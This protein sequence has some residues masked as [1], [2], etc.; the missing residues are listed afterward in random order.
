[1]S[2]RLELDGRIA[3]LVIDRPDKRNAMS[4]AMW[5]AI[6]ELVERVRADD[7]VRVLLVRGGEHFSAGADIGEF[8]ELRRGV[9]ATARYS[10]VVHAGEQ[11]LAT[12]EKPTIASVDGFCVGGGCELALACDIRI[13]SARARFGI[14]PAKL[15]IVYSLTA[16]KRLVDV[17][18]PSWAKQVLLTG[19]LVDAAVALRIGLVNEV[20]EDLGARTAELAAVIA[21]RA[22]V[23]VLG[24]KQIVER[25][26]AGE[27]EESAEVAELYDAAVR[28]AEYAEG[29]AAFL[30]KRAPVF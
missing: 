18:G 10:A 1:M 22:P 30:E 11:A 7:A 5:R 9:E 23:S 26:V 14:T 20:V 29:V 8:G 2:L 13:A 17:V 15:G 27:R 19:E 4:F 12:L 16:T 25:V 24:M 28:S 21:S 6:P 3:T